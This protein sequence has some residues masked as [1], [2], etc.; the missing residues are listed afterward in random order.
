MASFAKDQPPKQGA[1]ACGGPWGFQV[2]GEQPVLQ[3]QV[4]GTQGP[5]CSGGGNLE[6]AVIVAVV[7]LWHWKSWGWWQCTA[8][9]GQ[10]SSLPSSLAPSLPVA[11]RAKGRCPDALL[12]VGV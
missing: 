9:P 8:F 11:P 10:V 7:A 12:E 1:R 4:L 6:V 3:E 2:P 5:G